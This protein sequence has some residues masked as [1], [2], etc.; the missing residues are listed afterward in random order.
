MPKMEYLGYQS[1]SNIGVGTIAIPQTIQYIAP[2]AFFNNTE[3]TDFIY[4]DNNTPV[5]N[6]IINDYA[7]LVNGALYTK[8]ANGKFVLSSYPTGKTDII[9]EVAENT[10]RI[11]LYAAGNN[12]Y[13]TKIILPDTIISVGNMAFFGCYAL[14]TVEF[15]ATVAPTLEG[16]L[17]GSE[18]DYNYTEGKPAYDLLNK[19]LVLNGFYPYYYGQF[20]FMVGTSERLK[21]V[22]PSNSVEGY[23]NILYSLYFD[24][25]DIERTTFVSKDKY[26]L[27]YLDKIVLVPTGK[28]T[29]KDDKAITDARAAYNAL[30]QNLKDF[31]Y[32]MDELNA[33]YENLVRAE[34]DYKELKTAQV[35]SRYVDLI[36]EIKALGSEFNI[37]KVDDY[38]KLALELQKIDE[39]DKEYMDTS[40][41]DNFKINYENYIK[42]LT[43]EVDTLKQ[44]SELPTYDVARAALVA[45]LSIAQ[46]L[47]TCCF[48]IFGKRWFF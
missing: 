17:A 26:T 21:L 20:K 33:L 4:L 3:Q 9:C 1:L 25:D 28:I 19:Y 32:D 10:S 34:K 12:P 47:L 29:L 13:I 24:M 40:N 39:N 37:S 23:D 8:S 48:L 5:N 41:V 11:E 30:R 36:A 38:A 2:T 42:N 22:L 14:T 16:S 45:G 44:I 27:N 7:K 6:G 31:N 46:S 43:E 35:S 18:S 15:R